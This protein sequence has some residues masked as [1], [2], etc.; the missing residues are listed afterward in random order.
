M[1]KPQEEYPLNAAEVKLLGEYEA[2]IADLNSQ[3][4]GALQLIVRAHALEGVWAL[5]LAGR[6]L[7]RQE[8]K[9]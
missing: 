7:I 6:R 8:T 3:K 1:A 9:R 2:A 4:K 5:D